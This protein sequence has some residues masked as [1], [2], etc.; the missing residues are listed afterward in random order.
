MGSLLH[1]VFFHQSSGATIIDMTTAME[2][3]KWRESLLNALF[4]VTHLL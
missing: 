3:R 2:Q 4:D 1:R